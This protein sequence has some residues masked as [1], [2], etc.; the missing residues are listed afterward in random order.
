[1][2]EKSIGTYIACVLPDRFNSQRAFQ[3]WFH[4]ICRNQI[5]SHVPIQ[6]LTKMLQKGIAYV[7]Y[8]KEPERNIN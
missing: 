1:M 4:I 6:W 8:Q 3:D 2:A 7:R 5:T